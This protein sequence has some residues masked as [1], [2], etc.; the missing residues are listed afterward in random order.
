[1]AIPAAII[2]GAMDLTIAM[3]KAYPHAK[4]SYDEWRR[5]L[6]QMQREG[7]DPTIKDLARF[8]RRIRENTRVLESDNP[9][10]L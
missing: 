4:E 3:L 7:R 6:E 5:E 8:N 1:M 10:D 9:E 2:L